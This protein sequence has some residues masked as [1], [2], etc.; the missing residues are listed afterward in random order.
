[1]S[2]RIQSR[3]Y[4]AT[5]KEGSMVCK[6]LSLP[7]RAFLCKY[8]RQELFGDP[9]KPMPEWAYPGFIVCSKPRQRELSA[10]APREQ[11]VSDIYAYLRQQWHMVRN[12]EDESFHVGRAV[13]EARAVAGLLLNKGHCSQ[14]EHDAL[15][16]R[17]V[18]L[19]AS[20]ANPDFRAERKIKAGD[21]FMQVAVDPDANP[22]KNAVH[23]LTT[24]AGARQLELRLHETLMIGYY[25]QPRF[26]AIRDIVRQLEERTQRIKQ[27]VT[28]QGLQSAYAQFRRDLSESM[29]H[30]VIDFA[31][32]LWSELGIFCFVMPF[33]P[34]ALAAKRAAAA[35]RDALASGR[36]DHLAA[37]DAHMVELYVRVMLMRLIVRIERDVILP[38]TVLEIRQ[39][40]PEDD[41]SRRRIFEVVRKDVADLAARVRAES[42][43]SLSRLTGLDAWLQK[44]DFCQRNTFE[45]HRLVREDAKAFVRYLTFA[46]VRL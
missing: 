24:H 19:E 2:W 21:L 12:T 23:A 14:E 29:R 33:S 16:Q 39:P 40:A 25:L 20:Y 10:T 38:L 35:I 9:P 41:A 43:K 28:P 15:I 27:I 22:S 5:V 46:E 1:M 17:I 26:L 36:V 13:H 6:G 31:E 32:E 7:G 3:T 4:R 8:S 30:K 18:A 11:I 44:L 37:L 34:H 45:N 42:T